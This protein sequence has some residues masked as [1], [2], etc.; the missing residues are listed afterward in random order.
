MRTP[1][2]YRSLVI[3]GQSGS[4]KSTAVD[5]VVSTYGRFR[6]RG[7]APGYVFLVD[8]KGEHVAPRTGVHVVGSY[9]DIDGSEA[10]Y[11]AVVDRWSETAMARGNCFLCADEMDLAVPGDGRRCGRGPLRVAMHGRGRGVSYCWVARRPAELPRNLTSQATELLV[12][13]LSEP[14]DLAYV[15][16][17]GLDD[18]VVRSLHVG[19]FLHQRAGQLAH[20]HEHVLD[21]GSCLEGVT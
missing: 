3:L 12:F 19:Q 16:A 11:Q 1:D 17:R 13:R 5:V 2:G 21:A 9:R 14:A 4:G 6:P 18:D 20:L 8:P 7:W 15:R 10:P